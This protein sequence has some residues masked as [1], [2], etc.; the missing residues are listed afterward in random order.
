[1][2]G[3]FQWWPK[4]ERRNRRLEFRLLFDVPVASP[5]SSVFAPVGRV[6]PVHGP[7]YPPVAVSHGLLPLDGH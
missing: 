6:L 7:D 5:G 4:N 2:G 3:T 1:M